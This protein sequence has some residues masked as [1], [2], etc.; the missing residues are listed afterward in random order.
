MRTDL[1]DHG[2]EIVRNVTESVPQSVDPAW[3]GVECRSEIRVG[4]D[5]PARV[6]VLDPMTSLGPSFHARVA[7]KSSKGLKLRVP[8]SVLPGSVVQIRFGDGI[9]LG[10]VKY[11]IPVEDEFDIGI[12]LK[13]DW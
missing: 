10:E 3:Y 11:C 9:V 13:E 1:N 8:R 5:S 12:C 2:R 7:N 6:K 4:E